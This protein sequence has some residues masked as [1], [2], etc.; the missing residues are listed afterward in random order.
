MD[1]DGPKSQLMVKDHLISHGLFLC[2]LCGPTRV[3]SGK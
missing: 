1:V 3:V 2:E